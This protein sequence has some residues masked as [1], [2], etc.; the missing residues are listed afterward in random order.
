M[1]DLLPVVA[2]MVPVALFALACMAIGAGLLAVVQVVWRR[3]R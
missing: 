1:T 2:T 3:W